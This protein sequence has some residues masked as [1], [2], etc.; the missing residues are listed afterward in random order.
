ML[1]HEVGSPGTAFSLVNGIFVLT[2]DGTGS[3]IKPI[4]GLVSGG[5]SRPCG[6]PPIGGRPTNFEMGDGW[7]PSLSETLLSVT[8]SRNRSRRIPSSSGD[9]SFQVL[10]NRGREGATIEF[11]ISGFPKQQLNI[12]VLGECN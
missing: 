2:N 8:M 1:K 5:R 9:F 3:T 4:I 11:R 6:S 10:K 12:S 7:L